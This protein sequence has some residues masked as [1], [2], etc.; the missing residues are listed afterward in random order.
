MLI[1]LVYIS[2]MRQPISATECAAI[3][4]KSRTNNAAVGVTGLLVV[5][6]NRFLQLLEGEEEAVMER[7]DAIRADP[8]H[9]GIVLLDKR[10]TDVRQCPDWAMGFIESASHVTGDSLSEIVDRLVSPIEDSY[11]RAQFTGFAALHDRAA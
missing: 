5:G 7:F 6:G 11:L 2:T 8:R 4:G 10:V 1:Q 9:F 3:L